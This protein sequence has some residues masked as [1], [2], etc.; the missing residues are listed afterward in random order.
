MA[1]SRTRVVRLPNGFEYTDVP[2]SVSDEDA[3]EHYKS[4]FSKDENPPKQP[5]E[6]EEEEEKEESPSPSMGMYGGQLANLRSLQGEDIPEPKS[7]GEMA[8]DF[9]DEANAV[10]I[11]FGRLAADTKADAIRLGTY[12]VSRLL[13]SDQRKL[14]DKVLNAPEFQ[15]FIAEKSAEPIAKVINEDIRTLYDPTTGRIFPMDTA[16][17]TTAEVGTYLYGG[18]KTFKNLPDLLTKSKV[19]RNNFFKSTSSGIIVDQALTNP[20]QN[21]STVVKEALGEEASKEFDNYLF[22]ATDADDSESIKRLK[23]IGEGATLGAIIDA[24]MLGGAKANQFKK[25][26]KTKFNK[27]P[28]QLTKE[29]KG[30]LLVDYAKEQKEIVTKGEWKDPNFTAKTGD[31]IL[32]DASSIRNLQEQPELRFNE[33][34]EGEAQIKMQQSSGLNRIFRNLFTSRGYWTPRAFDAFNDSK[35]AERATVNEAEVISRKLNNSLKS[36]SGEDP[37]ILSRVNK[38]FTEK[39]DDSSS[40]FLN[41]VENISIK[42]DLPEELAAQVLEGRNFIDQLSDKLTTSSM[43][44]G[45]LKTTIE[46]NMGSYIRRSFRLFEDPNYKPSDEVKE[47]AIDFIAQTYMNEGRQANLA[48]QAAELDV[49]SI[50]NKGDNAGLDYIASV[51]K[52]NNNIFKS[53]EDVPLAIRKLMGE[54]ENADESFLITAQKMSKFSED[55]RFYDN[56]LRLGEG[57]YIFK[58]ARSAQSDVPPGTQPV[59]S[60]EPKLTITSDADEVIFDTDVYNTKIS[61]TGSQLDFAKNGEYEYYTTPEIAGALQQEQGTISFNVKGSMFG[62]FLDGTVRNLLSLKGFS[63]KSKTVYSVPTQ[64]R[65]ILGGIQFGPANG[66]NPFGREAVETFKTLKNQSSQSDEELNSLYQ[67]YQRLGIINTNA[68][69]NEFRAL[70]DSGMDADQNILVTLNDKLKGYAIPKDKLKTITDF[71]DDTVAKPMEAFYL[72]VDDYFKV[73]NYNSELKTLQKALPD[74]D[75]KTLEIEAARK[76][77]ATI[78][79]YDFVPPGIKALRY[80]PFGSYVSF[81][82]EVI[83][84][85]ANIYREAFKEMASDNKILQL[86]GAQR[87]AGRTATAGMWYGAQQILAKTYGFTSE[88]LDAIQTADEKSWSTVSP[89]LPFIMDDKVYTIDTQ[90]LNAYETTNAPFE[91]LYEEVKNGTLKGDSLDKAIINAGLEAVKDIV[92]PYVDQPIFTQAVTDVAYAMASDDGRTSN[93][94]ELFN[95]ATPPME[96]FTNGVYHIFESFLPTGIN[97]QNLI[98]SDAMLEVPNASTGKVKPTNLELIATFMGIRA[99]ELDPKVNFGYR[100]SEFN[101]RVNNTNRLN[102]NFENKPEKIIE[103]YINIEKV[104]YRNTQELYRQF[105]ATKELIGLAKTVEVLEERN[106]SNDVLLSLISGKFYN[107]REALTDINTIN[108]FQK[109]PF[110]P[111]SELNSVGKLTTA[112]TNEYVKMLNT[113]L[114]FEKEDLK[115]DIGDPKPKEDEFID[116]KLA[117]GGE[118]YNV[119]QAPVEPDERIDKMTGLPYDQQAGEAFVDEEDR[120]LRFPF[121]PGGKV[122]QNLLVRLAKTIV[123]N[124]QTPLLMEDAEYAAKQ[125]LDTVDINAHPNLPEFIET[126]TKVLLREKHDMSPKELEEKFNLLSDPKNFSKKRG[127]TK[128]EITDFNRTSQLSDV[129]KKDT[130]LDTMDETYV[131]QKALD[132][133]EARDIRGDFNTGGRVLRSLGRTRRAEGGD[134]NL[135]GKLLSSLKKTLTPS[136]KVNNF[137]RRLEATI[138]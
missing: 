8:D 109:T 9:K 45:N 26:I 85:S 28:E 70:I 17:G 47:E 48:R 50:L 79:N 56:L 106:V 93:G 57:K 121:A 127:Y 68:T 96:R 14:A 33:T 91:L 86:R 71:T 40:P 59:P 16:I 25:F 54:I 58:V 42:Y 6:E 74:A 75:L 24:I 27:N 63:Q 10:K 53:K 104:R 55:S 73:V 114:Y 88:Q 29:D 46:D 62:N 81:P 135:V 43:V 2:D 69:I 133:I 124:S 44:D 95:A 122:I 65:N 67:Q 105:L 132:E 108:I 36:F 116:L 64:S 103:D 19:W 126:E 22:L 60:V 20:D 131:I 102:I 32:E 90:F 49:N 5:I 18:V 4:K 30:T 129:I 15:S 110:D 130:G 98:E 38:A 97:M 11:D 89:R 117:K 113:N 134:L 87:F 61:G 1:E 128:Q 82:A 119:P 23:L 100:I 99:T 51:Q 35:Y 31:D 84:T 138:D 118:V 80:M 7:Y 123:D 136:R 77:R 66:I 137:N 72:G 39:L 41:Q 21:I 3:W 112:L 125:I 120:N 76:I 78:P 34:P 94:K 37:E 107:P 12:G 111:K 101:G 115:P 52:L 92:S 83:R 13:P